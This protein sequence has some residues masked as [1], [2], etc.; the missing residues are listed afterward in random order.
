MA[1]KPWADKHDLDS[2]AWSLTVALGDPGNADHRKKHAP[3]FKV[4]GSR[5]EEL[6]GQRART[7]SREERSDPRTD[8]KKEKPVVENPRG[9]NGWACTREGERETGNTTR[10][11]HPGKVDH[12]L[13]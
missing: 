13:N 8:S 4:R 12:W 3:T 5:G 1:E 9:G 10:Q 6:P 2:P 11:P 7:I